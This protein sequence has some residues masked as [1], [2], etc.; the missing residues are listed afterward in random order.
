[1]NAE[2]IREA[3]IEVNRAN[4]ALVRAEKRGLVVIDGGKAKK[5]DDRRTGDSAAGTAA[6]SDGGSARSRRAG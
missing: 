3:A 1:M 5:K 4:R 2:S 6:D